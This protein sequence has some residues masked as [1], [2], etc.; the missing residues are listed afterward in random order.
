MIYDKAYL[1]F[2]SCLLSDIFAVATL[3][4]M[5][6]ETDLNIAGL[7]LTCLDNLDHQNVTKICSRL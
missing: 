3:T 1:H 4:Y 5:L 6:H 2:G 7:K